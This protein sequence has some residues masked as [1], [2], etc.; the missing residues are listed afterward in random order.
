MEA[1]LEHRRILVHK[2]YTIRN[3]LTGRPCRPICRDAAV[4]PNQLAASSVRT[5]HLA[6]E[7]FSAGRNKL[8]GQNAPTRMKCVKRSQSSP[9]SS[10]DESYAKDSR[11][12]IVATEAGRTI[13]LQ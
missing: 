9:K 11:R 6:P 4:M 12:R 5:Y 3:P 10:N 13:R 2:C 7:G 1:C 8:I